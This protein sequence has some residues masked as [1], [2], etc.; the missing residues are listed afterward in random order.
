MTDWLPSAKHRARVDVVYTKWTELQGD[1]WQTVRVS[2]EDLRPNPYF[3]PPDAQAGAPD[4]RQRGEGRRL[5][6]AGPEVRTLVGQQAHRV[7][8]SYC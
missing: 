4:R 7:P 6:P 2:F 5:R 8:L 1:V 3:Q